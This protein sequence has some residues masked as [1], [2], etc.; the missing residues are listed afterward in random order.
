MSNLPP[1]WA[2]RL[3]NLICS[4]KY[5]DELQGDMHELY[6]RNCE[7][8]GQRKAN[9]KFILAALTAFRFY[10]LNNID[11]TYFSHN[12]MD[13]F[14]SNLKLSYRRL[15]GD[16]LY[17]ILNITGLTVG[18]FAF[19]AIYFWR[20]SELKTDKFHKNANNTYLL[21]VKTDSTVDHVRPR[22][23][24]LAKKVAS[25][26][27]EVKYFTEIS[28]ID[29][30]LQN[31]KREVKFK[32]K[33]IAAHPGFLSIFDFALID[34]SGDSLLANPNTIILTQNT[35][36]R[37]FGNDNPIGKLLIFEH[38]DT[39]SYKVVGV[40]ED[41]P[42]NS[43]FDF[44]FIVSQNERR[45]NRI[46]FGFVCLQE[47]TNITDFENKIKTEPRGIYANISTKVLAEL[48]PLTD[49]YFRSDF[50]WFSHGN[51][52]QI[53]IIGAIAIL[54]LLVSLVN[55]INLATVQASKRTK[56][57]GIK[58]ITGARRSGIFI[59]FYIESF[60]VI[61]LSLILAILFLE[62]FKEHLFILTGQVFSIDYLNAEFL[63]KAIIGL[64]C[65][66]A[67]AGIYPSILLSSFS[68]V[69]ALK[70]GMAGTRSVFRQISVVIQYSIC[71]GLLISTFVIHGQL[72][73][74]QSK[75]PGFEKESIVSFEF[76]NEELR[77]RDKDEREV[78]SNKRSFIFNE[79][80]KSSAIAAVGCSE[81]PLYDFNMDCW[82]F[83]NDPD[84]K[85]S[86]Y[87]GWASDD[88]PELYGVNL[89]E[90][91]FYGDEYKQDSTKEN[92]YKGIVINKTA[93]ED[94]F[95]GDA[96]GKRLT[97]AYWGKH[98]VIGVI[99]DFH[100]QHLSIPIK[101]LFLYNQGNLG[102]KPVV[103]FAK[104]KLREGME[105]VRQLHKD[106]NAEVPF[107]YEFLDQELGNFYEKDRAIAKLM[108]SLSM[109]ALALACLGLFALSAFAVEMR[110][111]EIGIRKV[112]GAS[113]KNLFYMLS[114]DFLKWIIY[115][116]II[117]MP[118]SWYLMNDWLQNY[119]HRISISWWIFVLA[120]LL[121]L[122]VGC[123]TISYHTA[124]ASMIN[125][126]DVIKDE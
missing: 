68:P 77:I 26:Y 72:D 9:R 10:R 5:I 33:G 23:S 28:D 104:G 102:P 18:L 54:I 114:Q 53:E 40:M 101:P 111:K 14:K 58:K 117:A 103:R 115:S 41:V 44:D 7:R 123:L 19:I 120:G 52:V 47:N 126:I 100:F 15:I 31:D 4:D 81:F 25:K 35:A 78:M 66:I 85:V 8:F 29:A 116:A 11:V 79:L 39:Q 95:S 50:E 80:K 64:I 110:V 124:R 113:V 107:S 32:A 94:L 87:I 59:Q 83:D 1:K 99:E 61:F 43:S 63:T 96:I 57:I 82:G 16:K 13:I 3:L 105:Y 122:L 119:A 62:I 97:M 24:F 125:P 93:A 89:L 17:T 30:Y 55:Y 51:E 37:L 91:R 98:E 22:Y 36:H 45:W 12:S 71:I 118:I 90:G 76:V 88:F 92:N 74:M 42:S 56:E 75:D 6:H 109:I 84:L 86:I 108:S 121:T 106:V 20:E 70:G 38:N 73:F 21:T 69:N 60:L 48:F 46:R 67:T 2:D 112:I 27:P 34:H 49:I 65:I